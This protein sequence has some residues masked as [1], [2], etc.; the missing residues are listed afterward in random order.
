MTATAPPSADER[1]D[2]LRLIRSENVGPITYRRLMERFGSATRALDELPGMARRGGRRDTPKPATAAIAKAELD[3]VQDLGGTSLVLGEPAYPPLL[4]QIEDAPPV[5]HV[6]GHAA[7]LKKKTVAVVGARNASANGRRFAREIAAGIGAGG[8]L[9]ASGLA[10]GIDAAAHDG[11][12]GTG[13]VAVVAGGVDVIYPASNGKLHQAIQ[14]HGTIIG[15]MPP[16][17]EPQARH[18]PRRNRMISGLARGVVVIEAGLKSGSLITARMALEQGREVF[19]VP[20]APM[21]P[22]ARGAN[23]LIRQGALLTEG[24]EDVLEALARPDGPRFAEPDPA[25]PPDNGAVAPTLDDTEVARAR[26]ALLDLLD[27]APVDV[28]VLRRE[29]GVHPAMLA[30]ALLE[31]ELAGRLERHPGNRVSFVG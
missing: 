25:P 7:L 2:R 10:R 24:A 4:A 21:D 9:V 8:F 18:F 19:A 26:T 16:G 30:A 31:L 6:L 5:L 27:Q 22:R 17:T 15:E 14:E 1:I 3:T 20:G 29:S 28:D 12:L 11:A 13:T 23:R